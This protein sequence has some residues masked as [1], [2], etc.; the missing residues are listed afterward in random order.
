MKRRHTKG[1]RLGTET[2]RLLAYALAD[3]AIELARLFEKFRRRHRRE[4]R[5][6]GASRSERRIRKMVCEA[7]VTALLNASSEKAAKQ[8]HALSFVLAAASVPSS[9]HLSGVPAEFKRP[10]QQRR[11]R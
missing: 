4:A 1:S 6:R 5:R 2:A 8:R 10:R 11:H 7:F 9:L 3:V